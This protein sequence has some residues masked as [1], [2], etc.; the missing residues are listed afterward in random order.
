[1][2]I[3]NNSIGKDLVKLEFFEGFVTFSGEKEYD[4]S[5][6]PPNGAV[7]ITIKIKSM[8]DY[9]NSNVIYLLIK[10]IF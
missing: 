4:S 3:G 8:I 9:T 1:M 7:D 5:Y 6:P 2:F 10:I